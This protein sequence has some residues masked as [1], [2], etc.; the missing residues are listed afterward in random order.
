MKH[1]TLSI[2]LIAALASASAQDSS[3][4][5]VSLEPLVAV[6]SNTYS[7]SPIAEERPA[8]YTYNSPVGF[9]AA[10]SFNHLPTRIGIS[11]MYQHYS[12]VRIGEEH[13][14]NNLSPFSTQTINTK[15]GETRLSLA[16]YYNWSKNRRFKLATGFVLTNVHN[17]LTQAEL[18]RKDGQRIDAVSYKN[19]HSGSN[20]TAYGLYA[21]LG[22]SF[23]K[24]TVNLFASYELTD[25]RYFSNAE[26]KARNGFICGLAAG[27]VIFRK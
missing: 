5:A 24:I 8:H 12:S 13:T 19:G 3:R 15:Q 11:L 14:G 21:G 9:G 25:T 18:I 4:F 10:L 2:V 16:P 17:R 1:L 22:T 20:K 6:M 7:F 23:H 26:S 27:Y